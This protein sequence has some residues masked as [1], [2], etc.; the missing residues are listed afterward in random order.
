MDP[1]HR[2]ASLVISVTAAPFFGHV[3]VHHDCG[4]TFCLRWRALTA[5]TTVE[6]RFQNKQHLV[7]VVRCLEV[8]IISFGELTEIYPQG[9]E[10]RTTNGYA[11]NCR[12][13]T[14]KVPMLQRSLGT[15]LCNPI[16]ESPPLSHP[17]T[18]QKRRS[19]IDVLLP[20]ERDMSTCPDK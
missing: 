3:P 4:E 9:N 14:W 1:S 10:L 6:K 5:F 8:S 20:L 13:R 19:F 7:T 11:T 15:L 12:R 18:K 2:P 17:T 16:L